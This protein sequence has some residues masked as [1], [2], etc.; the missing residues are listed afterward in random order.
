MQRRVKIA[1]RYQ[2]LRVD[3]VT[4]S[5][6]LVFAQASAHFLLERPIRCWVAD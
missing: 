1:P 6:L 4:S 5:S 3:H 2:R